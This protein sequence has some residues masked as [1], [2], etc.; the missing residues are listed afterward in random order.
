MTGERNVLVTGGSGYLG[1]ALVHLLSGPDHAG[2]ATIRILDNMQ[3]DGY[4]ALLGLPE[5]ANV[6]F[7]EG[8]ILD[9]PTCRLAL[10]GIDTVV[11]LAAVSHTPFSFQN[12]TWL[13][14]VN[15]WATAHLV[16]SAVEAG[17]E[18]FIH[19]SS[20]AVYGPGG[21]FAETDP[22]RPAGP[23]AQSKLNAERD[24]L[25]SQER[26]LHSTVLRFGSHYGLAPRT[27][28]DAVVNRF[29]YLAGVGRPLT[30][31]GSGHQR[32][33]V[34]H[35]DDSARLVAQVIM[36]PPE[37]GTVLNAAT[38]NPSVEDVRDAILSV[39]PETRFRYTEQDVLSYLSL[40]VDNSRLGEYGFTPRHD[41]AGGV[42][43]ILDKFTGLSPMPV[44]QST[45]Y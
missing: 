39:R 13:E 35:V 14:Q 11:H 1:S 33:P 21:P 31:F 23:Y 15:H 34:I 7:I 44:R 16:D 40:E 24:V 38:G 9:I 36:E 5:G 25:A 8:D 27:R 41:L 3:N 12:P 2:V 17:V 29:C 26:G 4:R 32:R 6:Q 28:F 18:R 45:D 42:K 37:P 19:A 43:E 22:C 30:I 10:R 20:T